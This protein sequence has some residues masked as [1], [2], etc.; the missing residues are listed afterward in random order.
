MAAVGLLG[1]SEWVVCS[2]VVKVEL[3]VVVRVVGT[4]QA[5]MQCRVER[6]GCCCGVVASV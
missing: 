2:Q 6:R 1:C 3:L 5:W 4:L